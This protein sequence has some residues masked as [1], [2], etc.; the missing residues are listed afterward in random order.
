MD[1]LVYLG[2]IV[3][4]VMAMTI[5][6]VAEEVVARRRARERDRESAERF[7]SGAIKPGELN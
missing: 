6:A 4:I 3:S 5:F 7:R 1:A 2:L